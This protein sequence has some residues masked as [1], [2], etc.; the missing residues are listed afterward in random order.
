MGDFVEVV[1]DGVRVGFWRGP[2]AFGVRSGGRGRW[3]QGRERFMSA[4]S[5]KAPESS[6]VEVPGRDC[7]RNVSGRGGGARALR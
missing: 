6:A 7:R 1:C 4:E 5:R 3:R 2:S